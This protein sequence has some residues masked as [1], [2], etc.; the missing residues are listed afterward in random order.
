MNYKISIVLPLLLLVVNS[1]TSDKIENEEQTMKEE[2][3][4]ISQTL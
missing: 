2:V 4:K 1:C 3:V